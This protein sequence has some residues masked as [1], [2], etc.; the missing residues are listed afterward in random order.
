MNKIL[1]KTIIV[2]FSFLCSFSL[3]SQGPPTGYPVGDYLGLYLEEI[4]N[5]S[6]S[7]TNGEKTYRLYAELS[8]GATLNMIFGDETRPF[9]IVTTTTFFN[10]DLFGAHANLQGEMNDGAFSFMPVLA[11]D[12]WAAIGDSYSDIPS[13]VGDV[14]FDLVAGIILGSSSSWTFGGTLNSDAAI[15]RVGTDSLCFPDANGRVLLGQFTTDGVLSGFINLK[16]LYGNIG[17]EENQ[18]PI[19]EVTCTQPGD[20]NCDGIVNLEDL[21]MV[22][23]HWL[24]SNTIG[25]NGDVVGSM[26]GIVNLEDLTMVINHWLQHNG[27]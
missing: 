7:F 17:W 13:T 19:P 25:T 10:Q 11:Y 24:Q 4:D 6:G 26:D 22:V 27:D 5:T 3:F 9:S 1:V 14:G 2:L 23:N 12:T 8:T 16:G 20:A 18:I 21:T 15:Y